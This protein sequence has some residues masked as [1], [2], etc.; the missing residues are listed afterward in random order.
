MFA[1][2]G[3]RR[4]EVERK[5]RPAMP[6]LRSRCCAYRM[7]S[8]LDRPIPVHDDL[9]AL[10]LWESDRR[11]WCQTVVSPTPPPCDCQVSGSNGATQRREDIEWTVLIAARHLYNKGPVPQRVNREYDK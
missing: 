1:A 4:E 2:E 6:I 9:C 10:A 5:L 7:T 8:P 3:N 11:E